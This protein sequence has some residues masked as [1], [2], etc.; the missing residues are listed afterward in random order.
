MARDVTYSLGCSLDGFTTGPDG[1]FG[2]SEPDDA[3][4]R[5]V[6]EQ[7]RSVDVH[8]MGRRLYE[9]MLFWEDA[10]ED[11]ALDEASRAWTDVWRAIPKIVFSRT[12]TAARGARLAQGSLAEEVRRWRAEPGDGQIAVGGPVLAAEAAALGLIDEYQVRVHPVVVGGGTPFFARGL[13]QTD[14]DLVESRTFPSGVL[15]LRYRVRR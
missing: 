2:W 14:L 4:F 1:G 3:V 15:F 11:P 8:L 13:R 10:D 5:F 7:V 9:T 6:T 12:L